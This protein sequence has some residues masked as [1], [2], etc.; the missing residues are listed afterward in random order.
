MRKILT[1]LAGLLILGSLSSCVNLNKEMNYTLKYNYEVSIEDPVIK[2]EVIDYIESTFVKGTMN[3]TYFA[4]L[5]DAAEQAVQY[6]QKEVLNSSVFQEYFYSHLKEGTKEY[7]VIEAV[8]TGDYG[9]CWIGTKVWQ[10]SSESA[11]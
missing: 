7:V 8:L 11:T 9:D 3:P 1:I 6:F 4:R 5:H 10:W 2:Q